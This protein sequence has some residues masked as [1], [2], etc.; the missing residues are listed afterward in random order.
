MIRETKVEGQSDSLAERVS[1]RLG[2]DG[3]L[4]TRQAAATIRLAINKVPQ[5][6]KDGHVSLGAL[7]G[8]Y[9]QYPYMPRLRDR[10]CSTRA[11]STCR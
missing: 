7:W 2:N 4:S 9:S 10:A 8:L 1:R 3:D 6:W 5:I 11:S